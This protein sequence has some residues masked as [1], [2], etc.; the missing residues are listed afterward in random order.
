MHVCLQD[1]AFFQRLYCSLATSILMPP[2]G[3]I[4][5]IKRRAPSLADATYLANCADVKVCY[6]YNCIHLPCI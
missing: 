4:N 3:S 2:A 1:M 5:P 6:T